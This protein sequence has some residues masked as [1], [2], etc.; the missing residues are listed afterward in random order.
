MLAKRSQGLAEAWTVERVLSGYSHCILE[1]LPGEG[2]ILDSPFP[3]LQS[4]GNAFL[5]SWID[6][7]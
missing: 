6:L 3:D 5:F 4:L 2:N 1:G 7:E